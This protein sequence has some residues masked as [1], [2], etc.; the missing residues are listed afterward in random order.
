MPG[1]HDNNA[2][3]C[4]HEVKAQKDLIAISTMLKDYVIHLTATFMVGIIYKEQ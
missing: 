1:K 2:S 3:L 4:K